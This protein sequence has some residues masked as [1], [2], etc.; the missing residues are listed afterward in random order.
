MARRLDIELTSTRD[1]GTWTWRAAGAKEPKGELDGSLVPEGVT[2]GDVVR[3]EADAFLE[4]LEITMVLP[5]KAKKQSSAQTLELLGS[6]RDEPLVTQTLVPGRR[7]GGRD[8][9]QGR[10]RDR[11][12][13]DGDGGRRTVRAVPRVTAPRTAAS[14]AAAIAVTAGATGRS[15]RPLPHDRRCRGSARAAP[16]VRP[17]AAFP[18]SNVRSPTRCCAGACPGYVRPSSR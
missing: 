12:R 6:G 16:I 17:L 10:G 8:G 14:G 3:V 13:R 7:S 11:D 4:G 9:E 18:R 5:P 1:D 15:G 2:V